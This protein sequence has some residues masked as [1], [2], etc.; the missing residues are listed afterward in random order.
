MEN[1]L[2]IRNPELAKQWHKTK[3]G[4]LTPFHVTV[5]SIELLTT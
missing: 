3:N 4:K 2:A 5:G 1:S